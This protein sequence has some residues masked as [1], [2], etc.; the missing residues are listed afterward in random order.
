[1]QRQVSGE[2]RS[3]RKVIWERLEKAGRERLYQILGVG[4]KSWD[5]LEE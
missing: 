3:R 2:N 1:M 5:L 4:S